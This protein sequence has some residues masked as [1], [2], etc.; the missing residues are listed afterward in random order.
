[1]NKPFE[2]V[3]TRVFDAARDTVWKA[4]TEPER[5]KKWWGPKGFECTHCTVDL[6]PGGLMHYRLRASDGVELWGRFVYRE[7]VKPS[8]LVF[9]VAFSDPK[10][11]ITSH[12]MNPDWPQQLLSTIELEAQGAKTKITVRWIPAEATELERKTFKDGAPLMQQGWSG[13]LDQLALQLAK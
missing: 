3:L 12:P 4:W 1:M 7:I 13:T 11:R 8:K 9:V 5:L 6:R 2:F 10:A